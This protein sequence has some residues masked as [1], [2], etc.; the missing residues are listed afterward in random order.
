MESFAQIIADHVIRQDA[1]E[2]RKRADEEEELLRTRAL[3]LAM[4]EH[5]L[6]TPLAG[7]TG[8]RRSA[9]SGAELRRRSDSSCS[10]R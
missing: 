4:A 9:T 3:F 8:P 2:A 6:K 7:L 10:T 1:E 5:E